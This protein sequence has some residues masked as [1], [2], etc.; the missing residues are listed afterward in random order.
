MGSSGHSLQQNM[1]GMAI[2]RYETHVR[3]HVCWRRNSKA[4]LKHEISFSMCRTRTLF[5]GVPT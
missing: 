2:V 4:Q 5:W 3:L 1:S